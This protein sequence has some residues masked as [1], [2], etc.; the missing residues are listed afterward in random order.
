MYHITLLPSHNS[1]LPTV[2]LLSVSKVVIVERIDWTSNW[3]T[4]WRQFTKPVL[5]KV[6][7]NERKMQF[8]F[9]TQVKTPITL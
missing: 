7:Q 8:I 6:M 4:K 3:M 2:T 5:V 9:D 1:D